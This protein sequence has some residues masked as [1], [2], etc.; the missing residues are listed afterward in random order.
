MV[1]SPGWGPPASKR[2]RIAKSHESAVAGDGFTDDQVLHLIAA[3]V[4]VQRLR[5][6][7]EARDIVMATMPLP[8]KTSRPH[9][10]VSRD[11][12]V[13]NAFASAA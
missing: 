1:I 9:E 3:F 13:Q 10:T 4:G 2:R 6:R 5:I 12:A 11:F 7:E 8:P